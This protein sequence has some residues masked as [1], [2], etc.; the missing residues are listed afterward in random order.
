MNQGDDPERC[1][2]QGLKPSTIPLPLK[3]WL[4]TYPQYLLTEYTLRK[5][6]ERG[7]LDYYPV[8]KLR[9]SEADVLEML[10]RRKRKAAPC[11][12]TENPPGCNLRNQPSP[13]GAAGERNG[14]SG[15]DLSERARESLLRRL[16]PR[17]RPPKR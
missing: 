9:I 12:D 5:A 13:N 1:Y 14:L 7:E 11:H 10:E 6:I 4:R 16:T 8:G 2:S 15:T 17:T 3:K